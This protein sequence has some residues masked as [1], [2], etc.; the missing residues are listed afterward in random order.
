MPQERQPQPP[1]F[2]R[3]FDQ[4]RHVG[5]HESRVPRFRNAEIGRQR[6][7]RIIRNLRPSSRQLGY[8]R[9]L[10]GVRKPNQPDV[11]DDLQLEQKC[12]L[13]SG[14]AALRET[15]RAPARAYKCSV[16]AAASSAG[17]CDHLTSRSDEICD[18]GAILVLDD[19]PIGDEDDSISGACTV[20][21]VPR[22]VPA[23][24]RALMRVAREIRQS[25]N[26]GID[27]EDDRA[28]TAAVPAVRTA[29]R[30]VRFA[31]EGDAPVAAITPADLDARLID[32]GLLHAPNCK[33]GDSGAR[34]TW[35][36]I[37]RGAPKG[38]L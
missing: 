11:R 22:A 16:A 21:V 12:L 5:D 13:F 36:R 30:L 33:A 27:A 14:I 34:S 1:P 9:G 38:R 28:A 17:C 4:P 29:F 24:V 10:P 35:Q 20:L 7:E 37:Q 23:F 3:A 18:D 6:R 26:I 31:R 8:Q 32:E 15:G 2:T 25:R 19:R